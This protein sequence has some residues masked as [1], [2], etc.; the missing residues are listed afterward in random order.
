MSRISTIIPA[1]NSAMT[2]AQALDSACSQTC[3]GQEIIVI[4]DGSTDATANIL[5]NYG[6]KIT[7][8]TQPN[9]GRAAARNAGLKIAK[10]EYIAFLDAD[11]EWVTHKLA[12]QIRV[13]DDDPECVLV[14]SDAIGLDGEG[15][16]YRSSMQPSGY[17]HVPT[18]EELRKIGIWPSI[19]SSWVMRRSAVEECGRFVE[20]FGRHWGGEDS[21]L[22]FQAR[23][24]GSFHYVPECLVRFRV[25][26]T[27][28]HLRKRLHG[29]D[30]SLPAGERLQQFFA[31]EK[32]YL[33]LIRGYYGRNDTTNVVRTL[34][35]Q[36]QPL[37]L[38][39]ALLALHEGDR[40]LA[41]RAYLAL[42]R[43]AP[44]RLRTYVRL[45]WTFMPRPVSLHLSPLLPPRYQRA[46][47]GPP[48]NKTDWWT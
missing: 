28:E 22:F 4:N 23:H 21:L 10:G 6:R 9:R 40:P 39:L 26:T 36:K 3:D 42:L 15:R 29:I 47:M 8:I 16:V 11:D 44:L 1:Y 5:E 14:Y 18:R 25:S 12:T 48:K 38:S 35:S 33:E 30:R 41:R 46:L 20:S 43:E 7:V 19:T 37:L 32:N 24:L 34:S 31:G 2:I 45:G 17:T 27:M 13:L